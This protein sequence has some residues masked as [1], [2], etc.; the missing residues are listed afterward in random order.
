ML[1]QGRAEVDREDALGLKAAIQPDRDAFDER[2][3]R[4]APAAVL[5]QDAEV[6]K[7][8]ALDIV[9]DEEA[10][11]AGRI[12]PF[13]SSGDRRQFGLGRIIFRTPRRDVPLPRPTG[14]TPVPFA[15]INTKV[16]VGKPTLAK[17]QPGAVCDFVL[18]DR[19]VRRP[20]DDHSGKR[21]GVAGANHGGKALLA[22]PRIAVGSTER[23]DPS[24]LREP[25][26]GIYGIGVGMFA[27]CAAIRIAYSRQAQP[28]FQPALPITATGQRLR[29]CQREGRVVHIAKLGKAIGERVE[30]GLS[31]RT[32][33]TLP[34]RA[35]EIADKLR[36]ARRVPADIAQREL[37]ETPGIEGEQVL[38][39][40]EGAIPPFLCHT[41]P[42]SGRCARRRDAGEDDRLSNQGRD[43]V[44]ERSA[45][46]T[47]ELAPS[48]ATPTTDTLE[49]RLADFATIGEALDYAAKG[50]RGLNFHD[51]RGALAQAYTYADLREDALRNARRFMTLGIGTGDRV[52]LVA[53]TGP[54]FAA[55]F[56]GAV[57]AGAW[58]VP[59]P[60]PTSF[61]GREAYVDQLEIQLKSCDPALFLYPEELS[62]FCREAAD[63]AGLCANLELA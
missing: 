47:N 60:L 22:R 43:G 9:A 10:E 3:L 38:I 17:G 62:E 46:V 54:D 1:G 25:Q 19:T 57:Y 11:A 37:L 26:G 12:E 48:G 42:P 5:T 16:C 55:C 7:D 27:G 45:S 51:A 24:S 50:R 34:N 32:P 41:P 49:R 21:E 40:R 30:I 13:Y 35:R 29:F 23:A 28:L 4:N 53:E 6:K 31:I 59:L 44:L 56:F 15:L 36:T 63:S 61:G 2:A 14:W 18:L 52:A 39:D 20:I 8:V 33:T 58:P